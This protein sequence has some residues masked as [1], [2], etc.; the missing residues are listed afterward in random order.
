MARD[1]AFLFY[2]GDWLGGTMTFSRSHKGAYM[3]LL[4]AQFNNGHM[5]LHD[6]ETILGSDFEKMWE[7]KLKNKF[8]QDSAG[9]FFNQKL[10]NEMVK[11]KNYTDSRKNNLLKTSSH[12]E[13][14]MG[15]HMENENENENRSRKENGKRKGGAGGKTIPNPDFQPCIKI[16]DDFIKQKTNL[17][18]KINGSEGSAMKEIIEYL[19]KN[20]KVIQGS[21]TIPNTWK[22]ILDSFSLWDSFHQGQLKLKQI[23]SNLTNILN[24]LKNGNPRKQ[25]TKNA[26]A[27][28]IH[29]VAQAAR[30][31]N[32]VDFVG[33]YGSKSSSDVGK[34]GKPDNSSDS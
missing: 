3:D 14:H 11:R 9:N 17:P 28:E 26:G 30:N 16:Y 21:T 2:P 12:K 7:S 27:A 10:E 20:E 23:N 15:S 5:A 34:P 8:Q 1:P 24:V 32:I 29:A 13:P 31:G 18:A 22:Y 4:M 19:S 33:R 25:S 6:I